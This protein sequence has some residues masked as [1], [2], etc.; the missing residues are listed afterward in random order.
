MSQQ[1][2]KL[3]LLFFGSALWLTADPAKV[4]VVYNSDELESQ[5]L[6]QYY[7]DKRDIPANNLIGLPLSNESIIQ[8]SEFVENLHNPLL[9]KLAEKGHI[10]ASWQDE[11]DSLGRLVGEIS[12]I[13]IRY[14]VLMYGVPTHVAEQPELDDSA[15]R[16]RW[17]RNSA[18]AAH[19]RE[20]PL[21]K[22]EASVDGELAMLWHSNVPLQGFIPNPLFRNQDHSNDA[23]LLRVARLDGPSPRVIRR[24]IDYTMETE[25]RGLKGAAYVDMDDR[26]GGYAEGNEWLR[27]TH[28]IFEQLGFETFLD[29]KRAVFSVADRMDA[30]ALYAGWYSQNLTGTFTLP[31]FRFPPGAIA[32]HIHS[33][34]A[35]NLRQS[36]RN[37]CGPL[38]ERGAT[39]TLG[40]TAEPFLRFSHNVDAFFFA[41]ANGWNL[42]DSAYFAL[43]ALSWQ[44]VVLGDP[45]YR[46]FKVDLASQ[47]EN[48]GG[49]SGSIYD[50]Y[51]LM[52][53]MNLALKQDQRGE[54]LRTGRRGLFQAPSLALGLKVAKILIE[55]EEKEAALRSLGFAK[56]LPTVPS[57]EWVIM[58]EIAE[59]FAKA[60]DPGTARD[61][62][63]KILAESNL[64]KALE[65]QLLRNAIP[66]ADQA[67]DADQALRWRVRLN[68][69]TAPPDPA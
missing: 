12:H 42:A 38:L 58:A 41:L 11:K 53:A 15:M 59:I 37:W 24:M 29:E 3:L 16:E 62:M 4:V 57:Q 27:R 66:L 28:Q 61:I 54:A 33:F 26:D 69:L 34:S 55:M 14:M 2:L 68:E 9:R 52:R 17:F 65:I 49:G 35:Q 8:R 56:M 5:R 39:A 63:Q 21:A 10:A 18:E 44:A 20:G 7:A 50:A 47:L 36:R 67:N 30:P 1:I 40:N 60:G 31:G 46:P 25:Q 23:L 48:V 51:V 13:K 6:A 43:P 45:L 22:N 64:P 32:V 19:F